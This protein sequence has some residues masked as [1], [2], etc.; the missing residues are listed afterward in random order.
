MNEEKPAIA[1]TRE[2]IV[3][4]S[5]IYEILTDEI[6]QGKRKSEQQSKETKQ[7]RDQT[8]S[9]SPSLANIALRD[10]P[11]NDESEVS[12]Q[13]EQSVPT[14]NFGSS[15]SPWHTPHTNE[16]N[17]LESTLLEAELSASNDKIGTMWT[18]TEASSSGSLSRNPEYQAESSNQLNF[19]TFG[20][21]LSLAG[22]TSQQSQGPWSSS[23]KS[24]PRSHRLERSPSIT[25]AGSVGKTT[26]HLAAENG[27]S[28]TIRML[29]LHGA[30]PNIRASD[31][32]TPL[33]LAAERG[34]LDSVVRLT[35][36]GCDVNARTSSG[37]TA[38]HLATE[39]NHTDVIEHLLQA[40]ADPNLQ[41][42]E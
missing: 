23:P 26:L 7:E 11:N 19:G 28:Q 4:C 40:G 25:N 5:K 35:E 16:G 32:S 42:S 14:F 33:H 21:Q 6:Y 13:G 12:S 38:L 10:F 31:G 17:P 20:D 3:S 22:L 39:N 27:V 24:I 1:L 15:I 18:S 36:G 9:I 30:D 41:I 34:Y 8:S 37:R 29:L 2:I